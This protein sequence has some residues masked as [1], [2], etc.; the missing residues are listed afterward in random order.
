MPAYAVVRSDEDNKTARRR[1]A[2]HAALT[3][4]NHRKNGALIIVDEA[5]NLLNTEMS[6]FLRGETQDKGWLN[7]VLETPGARMLW[8]TNDI[9]DI[10]VS[11]KRRFAYSVPFTQFNRR[12][13]IR[14]WDTV[15][16]SNRVKRLMREE[17]IVRLARE[18]R[19]SAGAIDLAVK[20]AVHAGATTRTV[21]RGAVQR[22]L[23]AHQTLLADG[24]GQRRKE[25]TVDGYTLDGL[26]V[27]GD[28]GAML[29]HLEAFNRVLRAGS[30]TEK[31]SRN[32]LFYGPPGTG[33]SELAR[34]IAERLDR[35]LIVKRASDILNPYVGMTERMIRSAFAEAEQEDGVL[36]IDEV[37]SLL[38]TREMAVRSWEVSQVNE[39]LAQME[40]F[41]GILICTTNRM[42]DM[43]HAML[44]RFDYELEFKYLTPEGNVIFYR[45]LLA[46]LVKSHLDSK[47]IDALRS[48][49]YLTPGDFKVVRDR[50]VVH[51][52][53]SV[54]ASDLL[55]SLR[56]EAKLK[57]EQKGRRRMGFHN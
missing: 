2:I 34:H 29:G 6:W 42:D 27:D 17:D 24:V 1:S 21:F 48:L 12:Q 54:D 45:K 36:V 4:V 37:D 14:L 22:A 19:A 38:F 28:L 20:T 44:R 57:P 40:R 13:R 43:D 50:F 51:P 9:G 30:E 49:G 35:E 55:Q 32:L 56:A 41:R 11:V 33:K 15:L 23:Q 7:H 52:R 46:P 31:A 10:D 8:I 26:H 39:M 3:M 25:H 47:S 16:R 53:N 18:Y 5:D